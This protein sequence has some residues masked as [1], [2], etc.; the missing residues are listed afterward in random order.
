MAKSRPFEE[1]SHQATRKAKPRMSAALADL[2]TGR[3]IFRYHLISLSAVRRPQ[4]RTP[5]DR[6]AKQRMPSALFRF[7]A[8]RFPIPLLEAP[9]SSDSSLATSGRPLL[10]G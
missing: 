7:P 1:K 9:V 6:H 10:A 8:Q 5:V 2:E 4:A 3:R